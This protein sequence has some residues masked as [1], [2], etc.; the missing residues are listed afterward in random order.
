MSNGRECSAGSI[1]FSFLLGGMVG[2]AATLFLAPLSGPET[3]RRIGEFGHDLR[4]RA[5]EMVNEAGDKV[6]YVVSKGKDLLDEKKSILG[7][8]VEAGRQAYDRE[9]D[10]SAPTE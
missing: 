4:D 7:A 9:K 3:R 6:N 8:A 1:L 2:A 10:K 5:D